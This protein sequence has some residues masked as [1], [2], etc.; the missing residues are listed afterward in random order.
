MGDR[1]E[2]HQEWYRKN[3]DRIAARVAEKRKQPAEAQRLA[4]YQREYREANREL[5]NAKQRAYRER[6]K[7]KQR[8]YVAKAAPKRRENGAKWREANPE[9]F[10]EWRQKNLESEREKSAA[11]Y[12]ANAETIKGKV[13]EYRE[14][15][16][17]TVRKTQLAYQLRRKS[18]DPAFRLL[19]NLR[20]RVRDLLRGK[21]KAAHGLVGCSLDELRS[22]LESQFRDGMSW[23]NYGRKGWH[24][25]HIR[26]CDA[27]DLNDPE[28]QRAAFHYTNL[29]P[30]WWHEN[31]RKGA[32]C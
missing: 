17:D 18:E 9:Y 5:V 14:A 6:T 27:F 20:G 4:E 32:K 19:L 30:L 15:N 22:H 23:E 25:D 16:R 12:A 29:Q 3:K 2:Y 24:V 28:Q 8:E 10:K 13:K 7:E 11:Y 26:P 31:L 1:R 21:R